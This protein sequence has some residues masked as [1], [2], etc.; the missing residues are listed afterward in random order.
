MTSVS[1]TQ[2]GQNALIN[3]LDSIKKGGGASIESEIQAVFALAHETNTQVMKSKVQ[4]YRS[5]LVEQ[6]KINQAL[7]DIERYKAGFKGAQPNDLRDWTEQKDAAQQAGA[8]AN[9]ASRERR[10]GKDSSY[11]AELMKNAKGTSAEKQAFVERARVMDLAARYGMDV[12]SVNNEADATAFIQGHAKNSFVD[13]VKAKL[14]ATMDALGADSQL[15]M[16]DIQTI[17]G[18]MDAAINA[19]T[20]VVKGDAD[21]K[22]KLA[23]NI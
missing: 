19:L 10:E 7:A 20:T 16:I 2:H 4:E 21:T 18:R 5:K 3:A 8:H 6:Q 9:V 11:E 1:P 23:N 12:H 15:Q 17:K 14:K 22:Q 13:S